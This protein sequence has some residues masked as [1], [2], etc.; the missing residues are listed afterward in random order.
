MKRLGDVTDSEF[1]KAVLESNKTVLVDFWADWCMPCR[2][3]SLM[4]EEI[5]SEKSD[6]EVFKMNIDENPKTFKEYKVM[7][8]PTLLLF[9]DGEEIG[10]MIGAKSKQDI[11]ENLFK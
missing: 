10:R 11:L 3:V 9:K 6:I 5:A 2:P 8:V 4:V 7:S 1:N